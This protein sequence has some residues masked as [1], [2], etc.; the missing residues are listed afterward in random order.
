MTMV[1]S[2]GAA[3]DRAMAALIAGLELEFG[4]SAGEALARRFLAAEETDF[5]W[6]SRCSARWLGAYQDADEEGFELGR[7]AI[8]GRLAGRWVVAQLIVDGDGR[9]HGLLARRN[10][11]RVDA[12]RKA[13]VALH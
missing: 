7:I 13:F 6:E 8:L 1:Q 5:V 3:S 10:F 4:R 9:P 2:I 11:S 12:A